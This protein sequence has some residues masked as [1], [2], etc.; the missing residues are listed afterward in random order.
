MHRGGKL[1][2]TGR[3][4]LK[5]GE[6]GQR[7]TAQTNNLFPFS[8]WR[9]MPG[10]EGRLFNVDGRLEARMTF[11][12]FFLNIVSLVKRLSS[13]IL[14]RVCLKNVTLVDFPQPLH[15]HKT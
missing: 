13:N 7:T 11:F 3:V 4:E 14:T 1:L 2:E 15:L 5:K 6:G 8:R 9:T 12:F 10:E